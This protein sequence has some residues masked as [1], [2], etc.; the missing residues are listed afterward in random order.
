MATESVKLEF[1]DEAIHEIARV[2]TL[3]NRTLENIGARRLHTIVERIL[4]D[5]SFGACDHAPDYVVTIDKAYVESKV[6]DLLIKSDLS[7]YIL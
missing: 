7:K 6:S 4:E 1:A 2:A 3:A 5:V